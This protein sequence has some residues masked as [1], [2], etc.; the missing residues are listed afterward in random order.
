MNIP[1]KWTNKERKYFS[2][3]IP[4]VEKVSWLTKW[5]DDYFIWFVMALMAGATIWIFVKIFQLSLI[6]IWL[7]TI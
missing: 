3:P 6:R 7:K 4:R 5:L 1:L 2:K